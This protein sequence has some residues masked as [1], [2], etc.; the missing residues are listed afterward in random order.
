MIG[1][2]LV[3]VVSGGFLAV[4]LAR[5][6]NGGVESRVD[7]FL[8]GLKE[9][10]VAIKERLGFDEDK[11]GQGRGNSGLVEP[12]HIPVS[13]APAATSEGVNLGGSSR[14][15]YR[16]VVTHLDESTSNLCYTKADYNA[17]VGLGSQLRSAQTF[18]QFHLDGVTRYQ[19]EYEKTGSSVYLDAKASSQASA[20]SEEQKIDSLVGQMQ[21]IEKRGY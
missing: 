1:L 8:S 9:N 2:F 15:C 17:L 20:D 10:V 16:Y 11:A 12:S 4:S 5:S 14:P 19:Q 6:F 21:E 3:V 7:Q 13:P 18:Y